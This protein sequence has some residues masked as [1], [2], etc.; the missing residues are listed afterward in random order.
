MTTTNHK[1]QSAK[2]TDNSY[3]RVQPQA[4]EVERAVLGALMIDK[5]AFDSISNLLRADSFYDPRNQKVFLAILK[6]S[7]KNFPV[8]VLSVTEQLARDGNLE[9]VGG[10]CYVTELSSRVA[11]SANIEYHARVI[12]QKAVARQLIVITSNIEGRAFDETEDIDDLMQEAESRIFELSSQN[13]TNDYQQINSVLKVANDEIMEAKSNL[14]D[15]TGLH[16]GYEDLDNY[17]CGWQSTD[18][19]II[20]GRPGMGKTTFAL[21]LARFLAEECQIPIAYF[22]LEMSSVQLV[23]RLISGISE[24]EGK[25]IK[26]GQY[27]Q[28]ELKRID[29]GIGRLWDKPFYL[30]ETPGLSIYELRTK[31]RRLV[32]EH[33]VK[34]VFIDYLQLMSASTTRYSTRQDEVSL[35]SRSLK[36]LAKETGT[37]ILALSQMNRG[38]E[39][40]EGLEGKRP[41]LSDLRESGAIEQDADMVLFVHRPEVYGIIY[42]DNGK[43]LRG[44]AEIIIGKNRNGDTGLFLLTFKKEIS[45]FVEYAGNISRGTH[46]AN[47]KVNY[48][49]D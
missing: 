44:T 47:M 24:V 35:I 25:K 28:T 3:S 20:A 23:K 33:G 19:N 9:E 39:A 21:C 6:L 34:V 16:T 49:E 48:D 5:N 14:D 12:V 8:D 46:Q 13:L 22:S 45:A 7:Q 27:D 29:Q 31:V 10:P 11:S 2:Q 1:K 30:D 40:R 42:D 26:N 18:L 17:T 38:V 43:D 37:T 15:V 32:K 41:R 36:A 4:L